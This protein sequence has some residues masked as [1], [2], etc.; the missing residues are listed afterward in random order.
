MSINKKWHL[1]FR[2]ATLS[3]GGIL[4][5]FAIRLH[6]CW[7]NNTKSLYLLCVITLYVDHA[8]V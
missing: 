4:A 2:S 1:D 3:T 8:H 7:L 5:T 6:E